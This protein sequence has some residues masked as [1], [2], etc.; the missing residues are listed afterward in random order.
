MEDCQKYDCGKKF[1]VFN[2]Y[3]KSMNGQVK[4]EKN[5]SSFRVYINENIV[6][7]E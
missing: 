1:E 7:S 4:N 5:A 2:Q 3:A 6:H